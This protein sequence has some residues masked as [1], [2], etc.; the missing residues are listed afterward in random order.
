MVFLI[1]FSSPSYAFLEPGVLGAKYEGKGTI[2]QRK[3][4][5]EPE[6]HKVTLEISRTRGGPMEF[7]ET[8]TFRNGR[9]AEF[10]Y[11][12]VEKEKYFLD[13]L[14]QKGHNIGL[15]Y[16][17]NLRAAGDKK[18]HFKFHKGERSEDQIFT[19]KGNELY[20]MGQRPGPRGTQEFLREGFIKIP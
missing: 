5:K 4:E 15:G 14:N 2:I 7:H 8:Y 1:L 9:T 18:C 13:L 19:I 17:Y 10:S 12:A 11:V 6:K 3:M 16:C 20:R